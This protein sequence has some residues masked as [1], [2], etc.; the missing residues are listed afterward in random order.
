MGAL[1]K[2]EPLQVG[3]LQQPG[4]YSD[5]GGLY[6][7]VAKGK[8]STAGKEPEATKSWIF[9]YRVANRE[10]EMGLGAFPA[11]SLKRA[12]DKAAE[13][14]QLREEGIDPIEAR[15]AARDKEN[16]ESARVMTFKECAL[17]FIEAKE[18]GWKNAKHRLQWK[19]TL[20]T[21][22]YPVFGHLPASVVDEP[23]VLRALQPIWAVKP[24]TAG[25]VR[26]RI[27]SVLDWA[28]VKK[29][30]AGENPARWRGNLEHALAKLS[31]IQEVRHHP[32]LP[33]DQMPAFM[34]DLRARTAVAAAALEFL[35]LTIGRTTEVL[36][37]RWPEMDDGKGALWVVPEGRMKGEREHRVPLTPAALAVL[38]KMKPLRRV[39]QGDYVFPGTK[40]GRPLSNAA[41][42]RLIDR[43]NG[44][45][46]PPKWRDEN[47]EAV[48]PHGF[49][50]SFK[51]WASETTDY[52]NEMSEAALSHAIGD[53]TEAA[54]R[55]GDLFK[56][57]RQMMDDW[58]DH[59]AGKKPASASGD[60]VVQFGRARAAQ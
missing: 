2:L 22:V 19:N 43:M 41:M 57:R 45:S 39:D 37:A 56:R 15:D 21:Y 27:E 47:G 30:R 10:R 54:Y 5:G 28:K 11:I 12:R 17:A 55:R 25:R 7:Q 13:C 9:R 34:V 8:A 33:F 4:R 18:G 29:Q 38:E 53:K 48:V 50:S 46:D 59:C 31:D 3:R 58:A 26:G 23:L 32:A 16:A 51:D 35:I 52:P 40:P 49:R 42:E 20:A 60:N 1:H 14:R 24:E 36:E 44:R 6:L